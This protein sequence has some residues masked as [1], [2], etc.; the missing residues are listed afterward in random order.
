[1]GRNEQDFYPFLFPS[2]TIYASP[3]SSSSSTSPPSSPP[4]TYSS[5]TQSSSHHSSSSS[6]SITSPFKLYPSTTQFSSTADGKKFN[7]QLTEEIMV[8]GAR[9]TVKFL[10]ESIEE[11]KRRYRGVRQ[12]WGK[13]AA[14]IRNP[15]EGFRLRLGIFDT[16]EDAARA[17]DEAALRFS[18][19]K[20]ILNFPENFKL[21]PTTTSNPMTTQCPISDSSKARVSVPDSTRPIIHSHQADHARMQESIEEVKRRYR[22][23]RQKPSGKWAAEIKD[24]IK[25]FRIW[26][27]TF[28]TAEEG[29]RAYDEAALRFNGSKAI[30]NFPENVK[31]KS[32]T[33]NPMTPQCPIS[34]SLNT[35]VS[36]RDSTRP[37]IHSHQVDHGRMQEVPIHQRKDAVS[38]LVYEANAR[39]RDPL[40]VCV[41]AI[42][43]LQKQVSQLQMALAEILC[44]Q[45]QSNEPSLPKINK[46]ND[47]N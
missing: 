11:G 37:I 47:D 14:E 43:L 25:G 32:T 8:D 1:M 9:N 23:V 44:I 39:V 6:L 42:S 46:T 36:V 19:S 2:T 45:M 35:R 30:L 12:K 17:Y 31:L 26:L 16:A 18:G 4:P 33:T 15:I 27:G 13:W 29:A 7:R 20:A 24:P 10:Q 28:D 41:G 40:N 22:G 3:S 38:S 5:S 21:R 34:D